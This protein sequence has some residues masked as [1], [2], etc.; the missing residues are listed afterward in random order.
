M[1]LFMFFC[2][3]CPEVVKAHY[4]ANYDKTSRC[5]SSHIF[6]K[7]TKKKYESSLRVAARQISAANK[8]FKMLI[9]SNCLNSLKKNV[10]LWKRI[11]F[12][13]LK[14]YELIKCTIDRGTI[15]PVFPEIDTNSTEHYKSSRTASGH[16]TRK[17]DSTPNLNDP[18]S[19]L[20]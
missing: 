7:Y 9:W 2:K 8:V 13:T 3:S 18:S 19:I 1:R 6:N 4:N 17:H 16:L 10:D 14:K 5:A 12:G 15:T 20:P 11:F